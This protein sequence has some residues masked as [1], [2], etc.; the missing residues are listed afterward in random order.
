LVRS[1]AWIA[2]SGAT[3]GATIQ[4]DIP[5]LNLFGP[6]RVESVSAGPP[7]MPGNGRVIT[8]LFR[9][10]TDE[11]LEVHVAGLS[12]PIVGTPK[13]PYWSATR[14]EFVAADELQLDE[15]LLSSDGRKVRVTN[16]VFRREPTTV[17]N[18]EVHGDHVYH[19]SPLGLLVHNAS[20]SAPKRHPTP[21]EYEK[22]VFGH[23]PQKKTFRF[24]W[25]E[26]QSLTRRVD[27]WNKATGTIGEATMLDWN[28]I[29]FGDVTS[30]SYKQF[31]D[32][33]RQAAEDGWLLRNN[34]HVKRVHWY[35]TTPLPE[36]GRASELTRLLRDNGIE[37][38]V[39]AV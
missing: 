37:Y 14:N 3:I 2:A 30:R 38:F 33:L 24:P 39:K 22:H 36:S 16:L 4:L 1:P 31:A 11:L 21:S 5:E 7:I 27:D 26:S 20:F 32:K 34:R 19:V 15:E 12:E 9:H 29:N 23:V 18:I 35:G 25:S 6:A 13:H 8:G 10:T 28:S 17:Y